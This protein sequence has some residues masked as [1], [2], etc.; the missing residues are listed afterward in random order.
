[1]TYVQ[2]PLHPYDC[3]EKLL[4]LTF[5][6]GK[7]VLVAMSDGNDDP[8]NIQYYY[9]HFPAISGELVLNRFFIIPVTKGFASTIKDIAWE[10]DLTYHFFFDDV[11]SLVSSPPYWQL[12]ALENSRLSE[13][14]FVNALEDYSSWMIENK[15][16]SGMFATEDGTGTLVVD[17]FA[18]MLNDDSIGLPVFKHHIST[19]Y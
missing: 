15:I 13:E 12:G 5:I 2:L 16:K 14:F 8:K 9:S 3:V 11:S 18:E 1:M 4:K 17:H 7:Y 6:F 10:I 19:E